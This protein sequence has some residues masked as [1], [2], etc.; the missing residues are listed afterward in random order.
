[1]FIKRDI[2]DRLQSLAQQFPAV[3]ILG[4]RQSGKTTLAQSIFSNYIYFSFEEIGNRQLVLSDPKSFLEQYKNEPGLILDEIQHI[5]ELLSYIQTHIDTY[6]KKGHFILTGSQNILVNQ[7]IT[8][9][10][11]GRIAI[12]TL[13]PLSIN[14]L[15]ESNLL[16]KTTEIVSIKGMYPSVYA[17]TF[18]PYDWYN[19]YINTYIE[20]DVRQIKNITNLNLFQKFMQLCAGRI[21]QELNMTSFSNDLGLSIP[22]IKQWL[23]VLEATYIIFFLQPYHKNFNKRII[24]A[25]KLYF[26]DTGIA[27]ALL[28]ITNEQ[29]LFTHYLRGGLFESLIIADLKKQCYNLGIPPHLYFWR[30]HS[31]YEID[32]IVDIDNQRIPIEIKASS[33][34][35]INFLTYLTKWNEFSNTDIA[36]NLIIYGGDT[37][38]V[39]SKLGKII[40]WSDAGLIIQKN[41]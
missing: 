31:G 34:Y 25:P 36:N 27:A 30:D 37:G 6:K 40:S 8:Q 17:D 11:A 33:T 14:E 2:S 26:Y 29:Q 21:G 28:G 3:A 10:L 9:S 15:K 22:A 38:L 4:P 19:F 16:P 12:L 35:T 1:M 13:L 41:M 18:K 39:T 7:S 20:R 23:S 24:K 32:C 5:P